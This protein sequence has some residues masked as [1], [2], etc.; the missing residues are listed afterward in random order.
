MKLSDY[1]TDRGM[2]V[3]EFATRVGVT[4]EAVRMWNSGNRQPNSSTMRKI[5]KATGGRVQPNDF[6]ELPV[7]PPGEPRE[8]R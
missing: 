6:F 7:V 1:L 5:L 3:A 8:A 4:P 2:T